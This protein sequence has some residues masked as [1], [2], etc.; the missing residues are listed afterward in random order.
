LLAGPLGII[1]R[2]MLP[3]NGQIG[4]ETSAF[5]PTAALALLKLVLRRP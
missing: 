1:F 4:F 2:A 3:L 5:A